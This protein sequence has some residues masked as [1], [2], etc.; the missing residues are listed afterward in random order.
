MLSEISQALRDF[1]MVI[2]DEVTDEAGFLVAIK[3]QPDSPLGD[4]GGDGLDDMTGDPEMEFKVMSVVAF[5]TA[6]RPAGRCPRRRAATPKSTSRFPAR[7]R[8]GTDLAGEGLYAQD[9]EVRGA[10]PGGHH[11]RRRAGLNGIDHPRGVNPNQ[12]NR[13]LRNAA[14]ALAILAEQ[15]NKIRG[16]VDAD[17]LNVAKTVGYLIATALKAIDVANVDSRIKALE[18]VL[19]LRGDVE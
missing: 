11:Q 6:R 4:S 9:R 5:P 3:S 19:R 10:V 16:Y 17:P 2:P 18:Q 7:T 14:D 12:S 13:L 8:T 1:G 15:V